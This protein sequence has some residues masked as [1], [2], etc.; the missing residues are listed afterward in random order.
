MDPNMMSR[1][2]K[3]MSYVLRHDEGSL[4][5]MDEHGFMYVDALAEHLSKNHYKTAKTT[6]SAEDILSV[7]T[8]D[9][10]SRYIV[11]ISPHKTYANGE[12]HYRI[13]AAQGHS[14]KIQDETLLPISSTDV[15]NFSGVYHV[16]SESGWQSIKETGFILPMS[17][18]HV[19]F[20]TEPRHVRTN[21]W[22][23]V[24]LSLD[25]SDPVRLDHLTFLKAQN[26]VLL[27]EDPVPVSVV[28]RKDEISWK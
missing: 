22:A 26:G 5:K 6:I 20:A 25:V 2:S 13:K 14:L 12:N 3:K 10:K 24:Y 15:T 17:R 28:L 1:L 18:R 23:R 4:S 11:E 9:S 8:N 19:H 27:C 16:T 7:A 21:D